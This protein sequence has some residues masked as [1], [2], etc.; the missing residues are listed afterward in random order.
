VTLGILAGSGVSEGGVVVDRTFASGIAELG[1][2]TPCDGAFWALLSRS[3]EDATT[4]GVGEIVDSS[5]KKSSILETKL[6]TGCDS[7]GKKAAQEYLALS[8]FA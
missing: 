5:G 7:L 3:V 6:W 4:T 8:E 2:S 1:A